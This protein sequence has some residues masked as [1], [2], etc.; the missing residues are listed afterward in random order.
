MEALLHFV[1]FPN[2]P[3][4]CSRH[5]T[6]R[7][8]TDSALCLQASARRLFTNYCEAKGAVDFPVFCSLV[9]FMTPGKTYS[10]SALVKQFEQVCFVCLCSG[11]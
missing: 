4:R 10:K 9:Q 7:V 11:H 5:L 8:V 2:S 3:Q 6:A 1:D